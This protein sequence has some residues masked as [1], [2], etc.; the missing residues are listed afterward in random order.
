V[1]PE[2][3]VVGPTVT[4]GGTYLPSTRG[5]SFGAQRV[6]G[7]RRGGSTGL[8]TP[9]VGSSPGLR[10]GGVVV[11]GGIAVH[12]GGT[13]GSGSV[14]YP[15]TRRGT[16]ALPSTRGGVIATPSHGHIAYGGGVRA[17]PSSRVYG[18]L[19]PRSWSL[20]Y[21]LG[22][23][24]HR[25]WSA[26]GHG[27]YVVN[28]WGPAYDW[29]LEPVFGFG[30]VWVADA[31]PYYEDPGYYTDPYGGAVMLP[32]DPG[33]YDDGPYDDGSY[34][35]GPYESG[36]YEEP[37]D[38]AAP[39]VAPQ[40][41]SEAGTDDGEATFARGVEA[42]LDGRHAEAEMLFHLL[43]LQQPDNGQ[44]WMA[45]MHARFAQAQYDGAAQAIGHAAAVGAFPRGYR[46]DPQPLYRDGSF[47]QRLERLQ[48]HLGT[49]ARH[50][51]GWLLLGYFQVALGREAEAR[52]ALERVLELRR[53][54][55]AAIILLDAL[56]PAEVQPPQGA[57]QDAF[58]PPSGN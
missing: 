18:A 34:D 12:G 11:H 24:H 51:D 14:A 52:A 19:S 2:S 27:Y 54:D 17:Y 3:T 56:L 10:Q 13:F 6:I 44:A 37:W 41:P 38:A 26:G 4:R 36:P 46:F 21:S 9:Y 53:A 39:A 40:A 48:R 31:T 28:T 32:P 57:G 47:P 1:A 35:G 45:L 25:A 30:T 55:P 58:P 8:A 42:F 49:Y 20:G 23:R 16:V 5:P 22:R 15:S 29:C 7:S 50:T 33:S 43:S